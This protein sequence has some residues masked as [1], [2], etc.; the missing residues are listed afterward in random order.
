MVVP[1]AFDV[2]ASAIAITAKALLSATGG[3]ACLND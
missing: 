1:G 3:V 2:S